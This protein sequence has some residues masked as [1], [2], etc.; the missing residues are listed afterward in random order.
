[1]T[2]KSYALHSISP[3]ST[4]A[5]GHYFEFWIL[6]NQISEAKLRLSALK[7]S[8]GQ[9]NSF[10]SYFIGQKKVTRRGNFLKKFFTTIFYRVGS[11]YGK[12]I[13]KDV[14]CCWLP[15]KNFWH[16]PKSWHG[17]EIGNRA[18]FWPY[19]RLSMFK[20]EYSLYLSPLWSSWFAT[21][22]QVCIEE[23]RPKLENC[24]VENMLKL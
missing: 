1:M 8:L 4:S 3:T 14:T 15:C 2:F 5:Y 23:L 10:V 12:H 21:V 19:L 13:L 24:L 17:R 18:I 11:F 22:K 9:K 20:T 6:R 16:T 7:Y